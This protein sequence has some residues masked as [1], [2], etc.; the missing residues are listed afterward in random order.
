MLVRVAFLHTLSARVQSASPGNHC[1][2]L[3]SSAGIAIS[4]LDDLYSR[5][6]MCSLC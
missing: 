3:E 4:C 5:Q 1:C 2:L 6:I